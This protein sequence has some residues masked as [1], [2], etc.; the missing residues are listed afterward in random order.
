MFALAELLPRF[1]DLS[2]GPQFLPVG[3]LLSGFFGGLSGMQG[4]LRSAF[5]PHIPILARA[6]FR[7][8]VDLVVDGV[9][10]VGDYDA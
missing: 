10:P 7:K 5:L 1:R 9:L 3:G 4:A 6:F 2:F 8:S